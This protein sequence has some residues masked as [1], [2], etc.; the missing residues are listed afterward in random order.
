MPEW[1]VHQPFAIQDM[2]QP[3]TV[4]DLN[5]ERMKTFHKQDPS[6]SYHLEIHFLSVISQREKNSSGFQPFTIIDHVTN[7]MGQIADDE[8][9]SSMPFLDLYAVNWYFGNCL[10]IGLQWGYVYYRNLVRVFYAVPPKV[11]Q[12]PFKPFDDRTCS[13]IY[14]GTNSEWEEF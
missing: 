14:D 13:H 5:L 3:A 6:Y 4:S 7:M 11:R 8:W 10:L 2:A 12:D 1:P 9:I